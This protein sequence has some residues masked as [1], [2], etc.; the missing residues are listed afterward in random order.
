M[1]IY[2]SPGVHNGHCLVGGDWICD[3]IAEDAEDPDVLLSSSQEI[4][5]PYYIPHTNVALVLLIEYEIGV[6]V[7]KNPAYDMHRTLQTTQKGN[8]LVTTITI[9][10]A[11]YV[12]MTSS[13][14]LDLSN[15]LKDAH[16]ED[17]LDIELGL[18]TDELCGVLSPNPVFNWRSGIRNGERRLEASRTVETDENEEPVLGFDLHAFTYDRKKVESGYMLSERDMEPA[19]DSGI[20]TANDVIDDVAVS[21]PVAEA[22]E[23]VSDI[24][25]D[26]ERIDPRLSRRTGSK[27][28]ASKT[29]KRDDDLDSLADSLVG[30]DSVASVLRL[31]RDFYAG[32]G[33][34]LAGDIDAFRQGRC[35]DDPLIPKDKNSLLGRS[36]QTRMGAGGSNLRR[37]VA[38]QSAILPPRS[39]PRGLPVEDDPSGTLTAGGGMHRATTSTSTGAN[40]PVFSQPGKGSAAHVRD[41]S[42]GN[43]ARLG[44][45]GFLTGGHGTGVAAS[46]IGGPRISSGR[47]EKRSI[48]VELEATD[49]LAL[50]EVSFLFAGYRHSLP[51]GQSESH[52]GVRQM[53]RAPRSVYFT[54]QFFT[55]SPTKTEVHRLL[56]ADA[57]E[58]SVLCRDEQQARDQQPL[59]HRFSIDCSDSSPLEAVE[60]AEYLANSSLQIDVWDADSLLLIGSCMFPLQRLLR[61]G[62]RGARSALECDVIDPEFDSPRGGGVSSLTVTDEGG[63]VVGLVVGSVN[64][65]AEN[66]GIEGHFKSSAY[67][68]HINSSNVLDDSNRRSGPQADQCHDINP[69]DGLNWRAMGVNRSVSGNI[70]GKRAKNIVRARPLSESNPELSRALQD[71]QRFSGAGP[72]MRSLA[73]VRGNTGAHTLNY[74][75]IMVLFKRFQGSRKGTLQYEGQLL[76]LLDVPSWNMSLRKLTDAVSN[77]MRCGDNIES[78]SYYCPRHEIVEILF[79]FLI[80]LIFVALGD[81][82]G[83]AR[84]GNQR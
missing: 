15:N 17:K 7:N 70:P 13:G 82:C 59:S 34:P 50:N 80:N 60:F 42:R 69:I 3:I 53:Q 76:A 30:G 57:G 18:M 24:D 44:R 84:H 38:P 48:D 33:S 32:V 78:V 74:D 66:I 56:P 29:P 27:Y 49:P 12:P 40:F 58:M 63:P 37:E 47:A 6:P 77:A 10:A 81:I 8:N 75:D 61:Q 71:Q 2:H 67:F 65:I 35:F 72:S 19:K 45:Y 52:S 23:S 25:S 26:S 36:L 41:L 16:D 9:G 73:S 46:G 22:K 83:F 51:S 21:K 54:F 43:R 55:C 64:V 20:S 11:A 39:V 28:H 68:R 14:V 1:Y 5:V 62:Q 31:S 79:E 4:D